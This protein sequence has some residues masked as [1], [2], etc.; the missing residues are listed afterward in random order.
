MHVRWLRGDVEFCIFSTQK[1]KETYLP[2]GCRPQMQGSIQEQ[3]QM[4]LLSRVFE[5]DD[6]SHLINHYPEESVVCFLNTRIH[7]I[8]IH[9]VES[10]I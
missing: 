5:V 8:A 6:A 10:F 9:L 3:S 7:G 1:A 4:I 2:P